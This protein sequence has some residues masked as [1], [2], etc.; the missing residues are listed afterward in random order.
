M[1]L[2]VER[3]FSKEIHRKRHCSLFGGVHTPRKVVIS[4]LHA[5]EACWDISITTEFGVEDAVCKALW[6]V[7]VQVDLAVLA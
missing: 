2:L 4:S 1:S 3:I 7:K 5:L 6:V